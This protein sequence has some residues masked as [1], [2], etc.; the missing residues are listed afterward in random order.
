MTRRRQQK[1][2][3]SFGML[4]KLPSGRIRA[5]YTGPDGARYAAPHTFDGLTD[6]RA[7]LAAR[8]TEISGGSW[9]SP[10]QLAALA[11]ERAQPLSEY[12]ATWLETRTNSR[13]DALKPRTRE[14]YERLLAGPLADLASRP[15]S[16]IT[17]K[18]VREWRAAQLATG[19]KTQ[20]SR[21]YG[22]LASI[23][24]TAVVDGLIDSSP[25]TIV[26]GQTTTTGR[27]VE[28]PTDAELRTIFASIAPEYRALVVLGAVGGLRFGEAV[29][30][31]ARDVTL[32]RDDTGALVAARVNIERG[33]VRTKGG[34]AVSTPK[35]AA[36]VRKVGVFG[37]DAAVIAEHLHGRIGDALLFPAADGVGYLPQPVFWRAWNRARK[38]AGRPDLPFHA[39]RHYA[40]TRYAQT[41]ATPRETMA[42]LG[43]SSL[44]A[45]MRYQHAGNRDDELA[46]RIGGI[47]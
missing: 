8:Q 32:E 22:L 24:R 40:G 34:L 38:A 33:I 23:M 5:R 30:L 42:R 29:A 19:R 35:S 39:L 18:R 28:P 45:A 20:A 44:G 7:W 4:D 15:L 11:A 31:R 36:G 1:A 43:H 37:T 16:S 2:R 12:A 3:E 41:G 10:E 13:G 46:A 9:T 17:P 26:G 6:A 21:A 27:K 14:E 47:A 25:C